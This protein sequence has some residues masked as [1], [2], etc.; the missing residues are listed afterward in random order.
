MIGSPFRWSTSSDGRFK[1]AS[2]P[3]PQ[4]PAIGSQ[5]ATLHTTSTLRAC[6]L[7]SALV[8]PATVLPHLESRR[9]ARSA[10]V[11]ASTP[12][13]LTRA[14]HS[15]H[16]RA[17]FD[18]VNRGTIG[19]E[20]RKVMV[21]PFVHSSC[22]HAIPRT[23]C[24]VSSSIPPSHRPNRTAAPS[25][26]R[27]SRHTHDWSVDACGNRYQNRGGIGL[28]TAESVGSCVGI[29]PPPLATQPPHA[30]VG[31]PRIPD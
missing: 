9:S 10:A 30:V 7:Q 13:H 12:W 14:S 29:L 8:P 4:V 23:S 3:A 28:P 25:R 18:L 26:R 21:H 20:P 27:L 2:C 22:L 31:T 17:R 16:R 1:P 11:R 6:H 24:G 15:S 5:L 19:L